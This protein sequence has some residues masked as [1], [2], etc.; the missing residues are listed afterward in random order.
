MGLSARSRSNGASES[1]K[2]VAGNPT[3]TQL[4]LVPAFVELRISHMETRDDNDK[5][6]VHQVEIYRHEQ[7]YVLTVRM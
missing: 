5:N 3:L 6:A 2:R 1:T 7:A 4:E